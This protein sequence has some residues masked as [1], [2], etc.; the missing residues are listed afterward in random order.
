MEG[1]CGDREVVGGGSVG[2]YLTKVY[3]EIVSERMGLWG[4][5]WA[6]SGVW[7]LWVDGWELLEVF[8]GYAEGL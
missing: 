5:F 4:A 1:L 3:V 8:E 7:R 6:S 2:G